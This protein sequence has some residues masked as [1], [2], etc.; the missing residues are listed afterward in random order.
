VLDEFAPDVRVLNLETAVTR[1][2]EFDEDKGIH[3]RMNPANLSC[4]TAA[5]PDACVLANNHVLDFGRP[6]LEETL[7]SLDDA[8][9]RAAGAGR[10]VSRARL[11]AVVPLRSG[12]R[13]LIFSMGAPCSG[14]PHGWAATEALSGVHRLAELSDT[15]AAEVVRHMG[16]LRRPGDL[17]V[18]SVHWGSNWGYDIPQE[19]IRFAHALIDGGVDAVHGHSSHHP[20]PIEIYRGKLVLYGCGD[21][22]DDYEGIAGHDEY[23]DDLRL[24][25][26]VSLEADTGRLA[27][28]RMAPFRARRMRLTSASA[29][30]T[31]WIRGVLD[32]I[33]HEF[34]VRVTAG[35][36]GVPTLAAAAAK[37]G[38]E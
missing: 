15:A 9:L 36:D 31:E 28:L 37:A 11:P 3:Y 7:A 24:L 29:E 8:G 26:L 19:Q 32:G 30:D 16:E 2:E 34:G 22:I 18:A 33:S 10:D 21:F 5:W 20:R 35:R 27:E 17:V 4:L 14:I 38:Q 6:G 1:C 13:V 23:R 12:R 25:Y